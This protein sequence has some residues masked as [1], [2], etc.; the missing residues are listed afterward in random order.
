MLYN[1]I[2]ILA[3]IIAISGFFIM[4]MSSNFIKKIV[5]LVIFQNAI[6]I[7]Y[8]ALGKIMNG[9]TPI[10]THTDKLYTSP[11]PQVLMLTAI[12]VGFSTL[13]VALAL[14]YK[15]YQNFGTLEE[16]EIDNHD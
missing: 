1:L 7:F 8:L 9:I 4:S 12:V 5:G 6:L 15:I 2:Y 16:S 13:S 14:I 3:I 10:I 11:L